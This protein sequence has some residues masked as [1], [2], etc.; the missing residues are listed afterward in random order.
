MLIEIR[1]I[2]SVIPYARNPRRN[3]AAVAKVAASLKEFGFRQPL[4]VDRD[5]VLVVGH[6]RLA[7][8]RQLGIEQVPVHVA[9]D[10]TPTQAKAYRLADNRTSQEAEWDNGLLAL[11]L[12]DLQGLDYDLGLTAFDA[13]ELDALLYPEP[14]DGPVATDDVPEPSGD[15]VTKPGDRIVLG[16]HVLVCGDSTDA[17]AWD[18]LMHG[19]QADAVWTDPPYGVSYE[20]AHRRRA[21]ALGGRLRSSSA[22]AIANDDMTAD[23]LEAFLRSALG[24]AWT[25]C[26]PGAA[27]YVAAP[28]GPLHTTFGIVLRELEVYRHMIVWVKDAFVLGR[29]DYHYRH[30]PIFY[31]WKDGA[32][33][34]FVDDRTQDTVWEVPRPKAS[35]DHPTMKPV[36]LIT[37][38]LKNSTR[39]GEVVLD[40]FGGSGST[41]VAAEETGRH[42]RLIELSPQYCDVIVRRWEQMTGQKAVRPAE[43]KAAA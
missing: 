21:A 24:L 32:A 13:D 40:P 16:N 14:E 26:R 22:S 35:A 1:P 9:A 28:A 23:E 37:R 42:A 3:D 12:T 2:D 17:G 31:G 11:E 6:T 18:A 4:V 38:A 33:H 15:P 27:W 19:Q 5:G 36:A 41:L 10:L 30:E 39:P 29:S 25:A 7:A 43:V 34:Y 8:A 20:D